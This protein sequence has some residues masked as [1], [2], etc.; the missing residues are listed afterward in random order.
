MVHVEKRKIDDPDGARTMRWDAVELEPDRYGRWTFCAKGVQ[1]ANSSGGV[2]TMPCDAV[3][4]V[5][6]DSWW[7]AWWWGEP[8]WISIDLCEPTHVEGGRWSYVDLELDVALFQDGT[9]NVLDRDEFDESIAKGVIDD[10]SAQQ[11]E[12]ASAWLVQALETGTEPFGDAGWRKLAE[13]QR[14]IARPG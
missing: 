11:V 6:A 4:L 14:D 1:H 13:A 10:A 7:V 12:K 3:Q 5:P 9:V 2:F 8:R